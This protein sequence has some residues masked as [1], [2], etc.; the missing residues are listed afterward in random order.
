VNPVRNDWVLPHLRPD[1]SPGTGHF[2]LPTQLMHLL[3]SSGSNSQLLKSDYY[4]ATNFVTSVVTFSVVF[5]L[6]LSVL[7]RNPSSNPGFKK[8]L[9]RRSANLDRQNDPRD[10]GTYTNA[11][12]LISCD[13]VDLFTPTFDKLAGNAGCGLYNY[14]RG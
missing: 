8:I 5:A 1:H 10:H 13:F 14:A 9:L 4:V 3:P 6:A 2:F 11:D 7:S 12:S